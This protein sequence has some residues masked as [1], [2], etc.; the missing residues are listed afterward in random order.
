VGAGRVGAGRCARPGCR[1]GDRHLSL[2]AAAFACRKGM[3]QVVLPGRAQ[4]PA[5]TRPA[6]NG[7]PPDKRPKR[8]GKGRKRD[9][10]QALAARLRRRGPWVGRGSREKRAVGWDQ[11]LERHLAAP[12]G[13][14][15]GRRG[16]GAARVWDRRRL[17]GAARKDRRCRTTARLRGRRRRTSGAVARG[18]Q[19]ARSCCTGRPAAARCSGLPMRQ[20]RCPHT[21]WL[22]PTGA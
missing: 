16:S 11:E 8:G 7:L 1:T 10:K 19:S 20:A 9:G 17:S 22:T 21:T 3:Q 4:R 6:R 13:A 2:A 12:A 5:P 18:R 14:V 15:G